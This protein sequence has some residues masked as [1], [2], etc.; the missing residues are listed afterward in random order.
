MGLLQEPVALGLVRDRICARY[1]VEPR[2]CE[3][4]LISLVSELHRRLLVEIEEPD[5]Q[6]PE[7]IHNAPGPPHRHA[8]S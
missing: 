7:A 1:R 3:D 4:D 2:R 8:D 6:T 5:R